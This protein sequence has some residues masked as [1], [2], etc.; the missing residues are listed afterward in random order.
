MDCDRTENHDKV[1]FFD[2][3]AKDWDSHL[4]SFVFVSNGWADFATCV[5]FLV[6]ASVD[7]KSVV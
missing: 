1:E 3:K 5:P 6:F 7:R 4:I 2:T